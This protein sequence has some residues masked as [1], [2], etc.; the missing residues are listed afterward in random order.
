MAKQNLNLP[1]TRL[2]EQPAPWFSR[3]MA[4]LIDLVIINI[5]LFGPLKPLLLKLIPNPSFSSIGFASAETVDAI[6]S[7]VFF[8]SVIALFYFVLLEYLLGQT[9]GKMFFSLKVASDNTGVSFWSCVLRS[10]FV[11]PF[12]PFI[13]LWLADP[14]FAFFNHKK[15]RLSEVLS[16][17]RTVQ[18]VL[19]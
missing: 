4:F 14:L 1:G 12:F 16:R 15:N 8:A 11:F 9:P 7:I 2:V 18:E 6:S 5:V 10:L 17:T 19:V 3:V 13:I